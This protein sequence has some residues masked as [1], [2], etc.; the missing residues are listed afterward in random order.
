MRQKRAKQYRKQLQILKTTF[1]FKPPIQCVVDD[2]LIL[3]ATNAS[4]DLIKGINSIVQTETKFFVTQCCIQ[5]LYD[6]KNQVAIDL[7]KRME[8]RRCG[9]KDTLSSF[10]CIKSI[11]NVDGENKFRYLVATQDENLRTSLRNIAG[12]PLVF[13]HRSVLIM[14]PLSKVTRRVVDAVE[15]M[16]LTQGLN[17]IDAGKRKLETSEEDTVE[18][19]P[20]HKKKKVKGV[21]P[22]AMKK[23]QKKP[24]QQQQQQQQQNEN[25][26]E[27]N[28]EGGDKKRRRRAR[29]RKTDVNTSTS[30]DL[31]AD[32]DADIKSEVDSKV[33]NREESKIEDNVSNDAELAEEHK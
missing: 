15:R 16:K 25:S 4:Y 14:E 33:S 31:I 13:L 28:G 23:K 12:V 19:Q 11:T 30:G 27:L 18:E 20:K 21:N 2:N 1:K 29:S 22:L 10:D 5:H 6:S 24:H 17:S 32:A 9:H 8:K 7:A 26:D 3:E